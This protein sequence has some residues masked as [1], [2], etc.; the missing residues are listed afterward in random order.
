VATLGRVLFYDL[1]LS[2]NDKASCAACHQQVLR[3]AMN[4]SASR[5][6]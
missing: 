3:R 2:T 4:R 1:R 6:E 5:A